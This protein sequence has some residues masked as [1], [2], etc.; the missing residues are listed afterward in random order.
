VGDV[1]RE[2][3]EA[4]W[5]RP[6]L[7]RAYDVA[8]DALP[9]E[10]DL[11]G[12]AATVAGRSGPVDTVDVLGVGTGREL[13]AVRTATHASLVRAWDIS[14]PMVEACRARVQAEQWTDVVVEQAEVTTLRPQD[15]RHAD[16]V[17]ALGAVLGYGITA[18]DRRRAVDAIA[19]VLRPGGTLAAVV[20]QRNGRPDW[21]AYFAVLGV[22]RHAPWSDLGP[23]NRHSRHGDG[24]VVF[25][26]Y[27][28][29]EVR[30]LLERA[31]FGE[32]DVTSLKA[33]G[34]RTG[35]RIPATSPNPL[36]VTATSQR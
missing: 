31:G 22:V 14:S 26:H 29:Q 27:R 8:G 32:V 16:L 7:V 25:H 15:G 18:E 28:P 11:I 6:E 21:A 2:S 17:V 33:W 36:L 19:G 5:S 1:G 9:Y 3:P 12:T 20:Q 35:S 24:A 23:G 10:V 30:S 34:R 4:F 13:S